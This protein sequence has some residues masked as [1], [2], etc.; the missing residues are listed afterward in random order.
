MDVPVCNP[1]IVVSE[2][3]LH[4]CDSVSV[5]GQLACKMF[6]RRAVNSSDKLHLSISGPV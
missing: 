3:S 2:S 1:T 5:R 4:L 6:V